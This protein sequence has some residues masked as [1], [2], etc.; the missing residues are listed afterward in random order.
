MNFVRLYSGLLIVMCFNVY[1]AIDTVTVGTIKVAVKDQALLIPATMA[2][3]SGILEYMAVSKGGKTYESVL[4]V[5]CN[6]M[7]F[8]SC[9]LLINGRSGGV[10]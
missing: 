2:I 10:G 5:D 7:D 6:A 8:H 9:L 4:A 1:A 3:D